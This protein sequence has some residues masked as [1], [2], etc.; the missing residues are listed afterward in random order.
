MKPTDTTKTLYEKVH[1]ACSL[2]SYDFVLTT[3][4]DIKSEVASSNRKTVKGCKLNHGDMLFL[5]KLDSEGGAMGRGAVGLSPDNGRQYHLRV[6][7]EFIVL[8]L[9]VCKRESWPRAP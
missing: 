5:H 2:S 6:I 9:F 8:R 3:S 1:E 7:K 4:R